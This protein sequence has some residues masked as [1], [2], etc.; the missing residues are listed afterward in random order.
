MSRRKRALIVALWFLLALLAAWATRA[1]WAYQGYSGS[2]VV[3]VIPQ[4]AGARSVA[5]ALHEVGVIRSGVFFNLLLQMSASTALLHA[6]E[7]RFEG[8]LTPMAV[9]RRLMDGDV[10]LHAVTIPEG[11]R[12]AQIFDLLVKR[13]LG[14]RE[15][16]ERAWRRVELLQGL[17]DSAEDLEGYLY[18]DTYHVPRFLP[19][20][21]ILQGMVQRFVTEFGEA[22]HRRARAL[23]LSVRQVI[24]LASMVE[25]ETSVP[26]ERS[27]ISSVFHNRL[28]RGMLLQCDPTVIYALE[29]SGQYE[30]RLTRKGL[31]FDSPYNTYLYPGL[32]P[33]PIA[34]PGME[35][36]QA[37]LHPADSDYLYFVSMNTGRH[38]FSRSLD[39]HSRAVSRYQRRGRRR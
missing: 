31:Q 16:F 28:R 11:F 12:A 8:P 14:S 39:E 25:R 9:R 23:G 30:G 27:L 18:P 20:G 26:D 29:R 34:S 13:G 33:G 32:P 37:T 36:V 10:L 1:M 6:G 19:E 17:D 38:H 15:G 24:T 5:G 2:H 22:E 4:G 35:S 7:Y 21:E 3:V